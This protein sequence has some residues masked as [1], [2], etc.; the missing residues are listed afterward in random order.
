MTHEEALRKA[1]DTMHSMAMQLHRRSHQ[2]SNPHIEKK[3][4]P[5][6]SDEQ[7]ADKLSST[8]VELVI[9]VEPRLP[10]TA[11]FGCNPSE[12]PAE[13]ISG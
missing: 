13:D 6:M 4:G 2:P 12:D 3:L 11:V 8:W 7:I 10:G 5:R 9:S 1:L